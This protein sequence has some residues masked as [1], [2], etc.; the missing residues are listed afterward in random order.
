MKGP[1]TLGLLLTHA[2]SSA[3]AWWS[4]AAPNALVYQRLDPL[5][6]TGIVS[7]HTHAFYGTLQSARARG[8]LC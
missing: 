2:A 3:R 4:Y 1:I 8:I 6:Q 7:N 5:M